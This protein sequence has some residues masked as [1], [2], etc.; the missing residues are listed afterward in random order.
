MGAS[1]STG[2]AGGGPDGCQQGTTSTTWATSCETTGASCTAGTWTAPRGGG[3][4]GAPLR[5]ESAHFAFYWPEGTEITLSQAREAADTLESIW[6][7]YF[8]SPIFFPEPYCGS[9]NKWKAAVHFDNSFPLWGG[10][11]TRDGVGYMGMW[12][13]PG[14]ARDPWGLAHE[15]MHGVQSTTQAFPDCGGTGCWIFES[16][17][18]WMPHQIWRDNVHC[19]EMLPNMPHLYYGNTRDRYCNW[20]FFEFLKDKHCYSAVNDM[21]AHEAP[22]GQGDPWQKLMLSRGWDIEQL[23]DLFGEWAMHNITWD[24]RDPPPTDGGDPSSVY[25][26]AYGSIEADRTSRGR[27]DRR[28]R[29]TR[30]EALDADWAQDRRFVSPYHWAPQRWGYNVVRLHPRPD[31]TSVRV[32]FRGVTQTGADSGWRWG[33]V[34]TDPELTTSRYS[35]LQRGSDG[36]LDLC[37][38]PGENVYLVVVATPTEYQ[39]LV[40]TNPSDGPAYPSIYRYPYMVQIDGAW[41]AGFQGGQLEACPSGTARHANGGGCAPAG[42]PSRVHVGPYATILGGEVSGDVRVEDHATIVSGAISGGRIGALSLVGQ[43]GS[44]IQAR[45]FDVSGSAIV[46]TTFYP[47]GWFGDNQS[48]SGTAQLLGDVEFVAS[49]KSSDTFYGFVPDDWRGVSTATEVTV[50]PPYAWRP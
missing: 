45:G 19:S 26:R 36:E 49:S 25:R 42:T 30:L 35:P 29:L 3:E 22:R 27:T 16:H 17:A 33:L 46:Q 23:N 14:A 1:T 20:Q 7:T 37:V 21:W 6:D 12:I 32:A 34:A 44:G 38:S 40:W 4:T 41:P 11:W 18:N 31:A 8:G 50:A 5:H 28:L 2:A 47:L 24:Y 43:G 13:G 39:K 48:V 10:G 9:A 15:F